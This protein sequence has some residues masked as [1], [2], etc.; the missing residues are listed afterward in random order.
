MKTVEICTSREW[1]EVFSAI[2]FNG[3]DDIGNAADT[4][5]DVLANE[6]IDA[7]FEVF[8][9]RRQRATCYGWNNANTFEFK[10]GPVISSDDLTNDECGIIQECIDLTEENMRRL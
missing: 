10:F 1:L 6:L 7:G 5:I 8:S 3:I 2:D 9:A 4:F